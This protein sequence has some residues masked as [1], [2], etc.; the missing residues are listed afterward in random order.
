MGQESTMIAPHSP[1]I[2]VY[3]QSHKHPASN[4]SNSPPSNFTLTN[5]STK[6]QIRTNDMSRVIAVAGG[7]G[8]MGKAI[9]DAIRADNKF[10]VVSLGRKVSPLRGISGRCGRLT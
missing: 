2:S 3:H 8:Q 9:I 10:Q 4:S 1:S 5:K 7:S 6:Q